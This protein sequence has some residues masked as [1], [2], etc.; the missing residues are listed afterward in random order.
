MWHNQAVLCLCILEYEDLFLKISLFITQLHQ[1]IIDKIFHPV[2][3]NFFSLF[4]A[5]QIYI[6]VTRGGNL[7]Y[8]K[9]YCSTRIV[10]RK[11]AGSAKLSKLTLK[12]ECLNN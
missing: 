12:G 10:K 5:S 8:L 1:M 9:F 2:F 7:E 3:Q 6:A 11:S 4:Y